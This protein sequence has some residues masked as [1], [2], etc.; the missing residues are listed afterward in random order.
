MRMADVAAMQRNAATRPKNEPK[1]KWAPEGAHRYESEKEMRS[2]VVVE[3]DQE[4][5]ANRAVL[6]ERRIVG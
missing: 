4:V 6:M 2:E 3:S 5:P 1:K